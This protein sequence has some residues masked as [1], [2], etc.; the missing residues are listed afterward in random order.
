MRSVFFASWDAPVVSGGV[1]PCSSHGVS[2]RCRYVVHKAWSRVG[3]VLGFGCKAGYPTLPIHS[4]SG[5]DLHRPIFS[6]AAIQTSGDLECRVSRPGHKAGFRHH[7]LRLHRRGLFHEIRTEE[8]HES[9]QMRERGIL[10]AHPGSRDQR[11]Q[12]HGRR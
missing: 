10:T 1:V 6:A 12:P 4:K 11:R 9:G 2:E 3:H 7:Q 8:W 5:V